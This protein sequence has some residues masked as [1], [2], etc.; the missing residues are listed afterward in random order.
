MNLTITALMTGRLPDGIAAAS[1]TRLS[2]SLGNAIG[3]LNELCTAA[4]GSL[5]LL[6][7][8]G[9]AGTVEDEA[10]GLAAAQGLELSYLVLTLQGPNLSYFP[11]RWIQAWVPSVS[12][13]STD[14]QSGS[15]RL[16]RKYRYNSSSCLKQERNAQDSEFQDSMEDF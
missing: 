7:G 9:G 16:F 13:R 12:K 10:A 14:F 3:Q 4:G 11:V 5:R 1:H 2:A 8:A 15:G 6:A